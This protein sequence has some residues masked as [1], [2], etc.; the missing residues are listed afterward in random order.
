[1]LACD[2]VCSQAAEVLVRGRLYR[3]AVAM[4]LEA[5]IDKEI[6]RIEESAT[7][8]AQT[9]FS[10]GKFWRAL[11]LWLGVPAA[12]A[13]ALAGAGGLADAFNATV[14]AIIALASAALTAVM[15]TLNAAQRSD[16]A[17][18]AAN[19]YLALQTDARVLRTIDL[20][21]LDAE[22]ARQRLGE[23]LERR[24]TLNATAPV[25]SLIAYLLGKRNI[26]KGRQAYEA[27]K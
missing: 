4:T 9:Q 3:L 2:L 8:S 1:L 14:A 26:N 25:P 18:S 19:A 16:Q 15:T 20:P 23:L 7:Y 12:A 5:P 22:V 6:R 27:D 10:S 13:A 11:N 24:H 21:G 17:H